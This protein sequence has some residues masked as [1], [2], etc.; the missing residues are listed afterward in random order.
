MDSASRSLWHQA[1]ELRCCLHA[2][3][4]DETSFWAEEQRGLSPLLNCLCW[5][6]N[7]MV[8]HLKTGAPTLKFLT[9]DGL[10]PQKRSLDPEIS[11]C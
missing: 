6:C 2:Q 7:L 9:A 11:Q 1:A 5:C 3:L 4:C 8:S 10:T